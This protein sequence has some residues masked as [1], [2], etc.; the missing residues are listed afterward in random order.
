M[1]R[2]STG[3][4]DAS[5]Y[6]Y[7]ISQGIPLHADVMPVPNIINTRREEKIYYAEDANVCLKCSREYC[8]GSSQCY[9]RRRDEM[10]AEKRLNGKE[11]VE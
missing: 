11:V 5:Y 8:S 1:R 10:M 3:Q 2:Y 9:S 4:L 6:R 7:M